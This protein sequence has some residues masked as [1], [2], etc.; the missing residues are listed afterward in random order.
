MLET[1]KH[2]GRKGLGFD[3]SSSKRK[4]KTTFIPP[5]PTAKPNK[6]K[7][8]E[9]EKPTEVP[10][11]EAAKYPGVW[12]L[13]SGC[14]RHMTGDASL[15]SNLIPYDGPRVTF[16][17]SNDFGLTKGLGNLVYKG[18]TI[19]TVSYVEG[20]NYNLLSISQFCDK[21]YSL[22]FC[23][24]MASL[25]NI[26]T[27]EV[28]LTRKRIR[29]I[30]EV[31]WND[32][33]EACVISK[34]DTNLL[35][36]WHKRLSHLNFKTLNKLSKEGLVEGLPKAVFM[37]ESICDACQ[38]ANQI[39]FQGKTG[40]LNYKDIKSYPPISLSGKK[41]V[42][43]HDHEVLDLSDKDE[44]VNEGDRMKPTEFI[45]FRSLPLKTSQRNPDS[46]SAEPTGNLGQPS[47]I[48]DHS[49]G[50]NSGNGDPVPIHPETP[51]SVLQP[52]AELDQPVNPNQHNLRWLRDHPPQQVIGD[53]QSGV[54]TTSAQQNLETML[55]CFISQMEP[56]NIE[57]AL[58][59]SDWINAMQ[60][61][62][63]QFSRNN[64]S[65]YLLTKISEKMKI[66]G[67]NIHFQKL[68]AKCSSSTFYQSYLE[69]IAAQELSKF[70]HMEIRFNQESGLEHYWN[71]W[72]KSLC[73][74][75]KAHLNNDYK[76]VL[77]L[78]IAC[79]ECGTGGHADDIT[80]ERA[81]I[82]NALITKSKKYLCQGLYIRHILGSLGAASEGKKYEARYWLYYLSS[83]GENRAGASTTAEE[84]SSD[85]VLIMSLNKSVKRKQV[86]YP[87]PSAEAPQNLA[88]INLEEEEEFSDQ[89]EL[90]RK[91][92]RKITS[93]STS[94]HVNP[95]EL[96]E[97]E[98]T[99]ETSAHNRSP[100]QLEEEIPQAQ[101][102]PTSSQP[103][104]DDA[105]NQFWQ[106]YYYWRVWKVGN[107]AE[108]LLSWDQQLKNENIIKKCLG[109]PVN[110]CC[111]QILDVDWVWQRNY[112]D[113]HLEH[114][115]TS[116]ISEFE[117]DDEDPAVYKPVL[118]KITEDQVVLTSEAQAN[119]E[120]TAEDFQ[121]FPE[122][123]SAFETVPPEAEVST[124]Q[125]QNQEGSNEEFQQ[126]LH[127]EVL[128]ILT[129]PSQEEQ[130]VEAQRSSAEAE[131]ETQMAELEASKSPVA[132]FEGQNEAEER[133]SLSR[134]ISNFTLGE[135]EEESER[136]LKIN[137][138]EDVQD[139]AES[140]PMQLFQRTLSSHQVT[141]FHFHSSSIPT[142]LDEVP[143][144]WTKKVQGLIDSA[145]ASQHASF[146]QEIEQME[147]RHN[148]LIEKSEET[149]CSNLKEI[150]KSVDKTLE[151]LSLLSNNVSNTME[152]YASME[153]VLKQHSPSLIPELPIAVKEGEVSYIPTHLN[154][155]DIV[156]EAQRSNPENSTQRLS[157]SG[158]DGTE[159]VG[160]IAAHFSNENQTEER[161]NNIRRI[162]ELCGNMQGIR[163]IAESSKRKKH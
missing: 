120:T 53:I 107:S 84:S 110:Y 19:Q 106:L 117:V 114:M 75:K 11:K 20:L 41:Y 87:S 122:A 40:T 6:Q 83:K 160:T 125:K 91:K 2:K 124:P 100:Q 5:K 108:Q 154:L 17:G 55:A 10:K 65:T 144:I 50:D 81:F 70:L 161:R 46:N 48:P 36:L 30:Y 116:P 72:A 128:E 58:A 98:P 39:Y 139:D 24:D 119:L 80:Q 60:E 66:V 18:L 68:E 115:V 67:A 104:V 109:V 130:A 131:K 29:N 25:K 127:S 8:K 153:V 162:K 16:G 56:K 4:G 143:E 22:E 85:N 23:K 76:L 1:T 97:K 94:G 146:R 99:E 28:I 113:L 101:N 9:K 142:L 13:D 129:N 78:V 111:E 21:G 33:K 133:D 44:E 134:D 102:S 51:T 86:V 54:R 14:S 37:K 42:L 26:S 88:P 132:I 93:P 123:S 148:K 79:L 126:L 27:N 163:E 151:I 47:N 35:W 121:I 150:S 147:A 61:E 57:E 77:E 3:L 158:L 105:E 140:L 38:K 15:L 7:G 96:K 155:N 135:A 136:T 31:I 90:Q 12:Y 137:N 49:N 95:D 62:L 159:A 92:K 138:E 45:P 112:E 141:N 145:L 89:G 34:G 59:D 71:F 156:L 118:S 152:T 63:N 73:P 74:A 43:M 64:S 69:M 157:R 32:V 149:H 52:E 103:Q 82:I